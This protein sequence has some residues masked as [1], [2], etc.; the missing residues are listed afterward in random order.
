[1]PVDASNFSEIYRFETE[2]AIRDCDYAYL[3]QP[4]LLDDFEN[5]NESW[6]VSNPYG[7]STW[8]KDLNRYQSPNHSFFAADLGYSSDQR[9]TGQ[10]VL[11]PY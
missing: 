7:S 1:M 9:L 3:K 11:T 6:S 8:V 5:V 2:P 10:E 4:I